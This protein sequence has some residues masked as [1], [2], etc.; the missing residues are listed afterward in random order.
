MRRMCSGRI[1]WSCYTGRSPLFHLS[2]LSPVPR[3][4]GLTRALNRPGH[5]DILDKRDIEALDLPLGR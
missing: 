3:R 2:P 4:Y 5:Y 1:R